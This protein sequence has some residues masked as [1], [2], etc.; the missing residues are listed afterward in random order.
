MCLGVPGK[1]EELFEEDGLRMGRV[2]FGGVTRKV[3]LSLLPQAARDDFF[4][5]HVGFALARIDVEEAAKSSARAAPTASG[6]RAIRKRP[7]RHVDEYRDAAT[8]Q[9][10][11]GAIARTATRRWT[12]LD[13][14]GGH[15]PDPA[16]SGLAALLGES[17]QLLRGPGCPVCVTPPEIIDRAGAIAARSEVIFCTYGDMLRV[18]G[19]RGDLWQAKAEGADVRV[20][21]SPLDAL[22]V[23]RENP[24]FEVVF[25]AS[26]F[27]TTAAANAQAVELAQQLSMENFSILT[28]Q[29]RVVPA[30][31]ARLSA[32]GVDGVLGAGHVCTVAGTEAYS[33]LSRRHGVPVVISGFEPVDVLESVLAL[34]QRLERAEVGVDVQYTRAV[35]VGGN[36]LGRELLSRVFEVCDRGWRGEAEL[37]ASGYRLKDAYHSRDAAQRFEVMRIP[38]LRRAPRML[39]LEL[40]S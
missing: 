9:R 13:V 20:V 39:S 38:G 14:C 27:E 26:G 31:E 18:R 16:G 7:L 6:S 25:L 11:V 17:V 40:A 37:R 32:G 33:L 21:Y 23:A 3:C 29:R 24:R 35:Q 36:A 19:S 30:I 8:V 15:D 1:L 28:A 10:L 5:V 4:L 2:R 34:V 22:R 12:L